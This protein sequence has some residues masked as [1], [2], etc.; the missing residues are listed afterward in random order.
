MKVFILGGTG[1]I[2]SGLVKELKKRSHDIIALSRSVASDNKL[3]SMG[4][5]ALRGDLKQ[6][7]SW[8]PIAV[9]TDAVIHVASTFDD[10]MEMIDN[11]LIDALIKTSKS[12]EKTIRLLYTGGCWLYGET[13]DKVASEAS[14][15]NPL[16][17]YQWMVKFTDKL[18]NSPALSTA[19]IHPAMVYHE[20]GG[21]F[22]GFLTSA[23]ALRPFEIWGNLEA[24]WPL[25]EHS[26]LAAAYADLLERP[27]L[28]GHFNASSE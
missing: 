26:D 18:L 25:I 1:S 9:A 17:Y 11:N 20:Q 22:R 24:R 6:P 14:P 4:A 15:F 12:L 19:I 2:G 8:A 3:E 28:T 16:P 7:E 21:V 5:Q 10:D 23:K 13:G 27:H